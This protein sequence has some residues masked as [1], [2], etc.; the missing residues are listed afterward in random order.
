MRNLVLTFIILFCAL[1]A[2]RQPVFGMLTFVWLGFFNPQSYTWGAVPHSLII[3][4]ATIMGYLASSEPKKFPLQREAILL[5][6]LWMLFGLTTLSAIYP[7]RALKDLILLSKILVMV[8][9]CMCLINS[10]ERLRYL[11]RV[12]ALSLGYYGLTGFLFVLVSGGNSIVFGPAGSFLEANN[13]IGLA[14]VMNLPLLA[15]LIKHEEKAWLRWVCR[16]M[17]VSSFPTIIFTYSRG[18]WL[19]MV[20]VG[21]LL[22]LRSRYKVR[23]VTAGAIFALFL[24]PLAAALTPERLTQRYEDLENYDHERSAQM[25]FGSWEYCWRVAVDRPLT[26][27]GFNHYSVMTYEKYAPEF[28]DKYGGP[29]RWRATNCH[30][31]WFTIISEHGFPGT[32]LWFALG[33]SFF[34]SLWRIR[35][36]TVSRPGL[37]WMYDLA[38]ALQFSLIGFVVVGTFIDAAYFDMLYY[39]IAI[40]VIMKQILAYSA[41][42]VSSPKTDSVVA[43]RVL[44]GARSSF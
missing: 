1:N 41:L 11:V 34:L 20:A 25:R 29:T 15:H 7:D 23:I 26:G 36:Q 19:G 42:P 13:M 6:V 2:L 43:K 10:K 14:L 8:F 40:V 37:L 27:G 4:A 39:L 38:G 12:I 44:V 9:M 18:A 5:G 30:S 16:A 31:A 32:I 22:T 24:L 33:G 35:A 28:L 17:F 3:A 21:A